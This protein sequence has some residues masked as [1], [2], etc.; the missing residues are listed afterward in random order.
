MASEPLPPLLARKKLIALAPED[1]AGVLQGTLTLIA[2]NIYDV[3]C[4]PGDFFADGKREPSGNF[5]GS[6]PSVAGKQM[7]TL[8]WTQD[9]STGSSFLPQL[10]LAGYKPDSSSPP[11]YKPNSDLSSRQTW[12]AF[13]YE[14]G[15]VK[16]LSGC[17]A[18]ITLEIE[19]G[20]KLTA[21]FEISGIWQGLTDIAMPSQAP[22]TAGPYVCQGITLTMGG[23][24]IAEVNKISVDLG[25][26]VEQRE[27]LQAA[28]GIAHYL[29]GDIMPKSTMDPEARKVADEDQYGLFLAGTT[30]AM[31]IA[32]VAHACT[33]T[34]TAAVTQRE[35]VTDGNRGKRLTDELALVHHVSSGDDALTLQ[36]T[37]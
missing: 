37:S 27:S 13:C 24:A 3:K 6:V 10:T 35:K 20:K 30:A 32:L 15:R 22:I 36:E 29:V 1:V 17:A 23:A 33:L 34:L 16:K 18:K 9:V 2:A 11:I 5:M 25:A 4:T 14:D 19:D 26:D 8:S 31:V 12:S 21:K 28:K 7:G